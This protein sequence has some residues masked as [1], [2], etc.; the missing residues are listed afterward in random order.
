[1]TARKKTPLAAPLALAALALVGCRSVATRAVAGAVSESG[2]VYATDGDPELVK[3]AVPFGLKTMEG[4]LQEVPDH[5]GLLR[6]LASGFTQ[7]GYAFVQQ[8]ADL[9]ELGGRSGEARTGRDRARKLYLR[10]REYGLRGLDLR[11]PGLAARLRSAK[12]LEPALA[13][14]EKEDVPL[15]YW[16]GAAWALAIANGKG[17]MQLVAELPAPVAMM[18]R[19]MALDEAF[20]AGAFHEFFVTWEGSRS[21]AEGGGP[22]RARQHL[23]RALALCGGKKLGPIV[24]FAET[25][26]VQRQDRAEF[27]R[28]LQQVVA[29]D[30]DAAPEYRLANLLAQRR[31]RAL[32]AHLDDLFA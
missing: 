13:A 1:V 17:D 28:V 29:A 26:L 19:G 3:A 2:G 12:D 31:A 32:L 16:T 23:D 14:V 11:Y 21:E 15:L 10:A 6:G 22:E 8:D 30:V 7:Y 25:V 27:T 5:Q 18:R 4:L 9:A 24:N 20:D